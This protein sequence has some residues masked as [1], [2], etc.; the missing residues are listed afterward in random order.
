MQI[1]YGLATA[2]LASA[3]LATIL[4]KRMVIETVEC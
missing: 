4:E 1:T 3:R 2:E